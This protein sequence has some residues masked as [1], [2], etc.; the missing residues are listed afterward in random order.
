MSDSTIFGLDARPLPAGYVPLEA[1][2]VIGCLDDRGRVTL[3]TR[4]TPG[5]TVWDSVGML[6]VSLDTARD[7]ARRC[8]APE[9]PDE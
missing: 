1:E 5:L 6:T 3:L 2:A 7:E 4:S 8:F 9:G